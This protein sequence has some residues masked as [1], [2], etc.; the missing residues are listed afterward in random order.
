MRP[1]SH[2]Q[3]LRAGLV[4]F[5]MVDVL[6]FIAFLLNQWLEFSLGDAWGLAALLALPVA[7]ALVPLVDAVLDGAE[8]HGSIPMAGEKI[9]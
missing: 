4:L 2:R 8:R 7:W 6:V 9:P 1:V 3:L 5:A